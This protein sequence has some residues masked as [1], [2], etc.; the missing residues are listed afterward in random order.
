MKI[1]DLL[2]RIAGGLEYQNAILG[3]ILLTLFALTELGDDDD[4]D[5]DYDTPQD[6]D[7]W[8]GWESREQDTWPRFVYGQR[9]GY[10]YVEADKAPLEYVH[11]D[12]TVQI[13]ENPQ[14][15][16]G[17]DVPSQR[18]I[19]KKGRWVMVYANG[20]VWRARSKDVRPFGEEMDGDNWY[21]LVMREQTLDGIALNELDFSEPLYLDYR[22]TGEVVV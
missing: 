19:A 16:E 11:R 22:H 4:D 6:P 18:I 1:H 17:N 21:Y 13:Y 10:V 15:R 5:D 7:A 20:D 9:V 2:E 8:V 3:D 14:L 12:G